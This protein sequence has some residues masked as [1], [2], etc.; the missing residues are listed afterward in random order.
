MTPCAIKRQTWNSPRRV[1]R[2]ARPVGSLRRQPSASTGVLG[3]SARSRLSGSAQL[4]RSRSAN[5]A[6]WKEESDP[7]AISC[8][9]R[10]R[11]ALYHWSRTSKQ[12]D[13]R[14]KPH[15]AS[16]R[17]GGIVMDGRCAE[18]QTVTWRC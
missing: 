4:C 3:N 11:N 12:K 14:T 17:Q 15:Y 6:K 13:V 8:N 7:D 18:W 1:V 2:E 9:Q 5:E 16:L 10:L